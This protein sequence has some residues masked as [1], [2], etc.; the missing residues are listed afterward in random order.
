MYKYHFIQS[1][2]LKPL[3]R[4][5]PTAPVPQATR[6]PFGCFG[7]GSVARQQLMKQLSSLV[8]SRLLI[9]HL[10]GK[11]EDLVTG[12]TIY[13]SYHHNIG[14]LCWCC[15]YRCFSDQIIWHFACGCTQTS[16]LYFFN[17]HT[18]VAFVQHAHICTYII[19]YY[20]APEIP[21]FTAA[22]QWGFVWCSYLTIV[23]RGNWCV[24]PICSPMLNAL[25]M[26]KDTYEKILGFILGGIFAC[27]IL[28]LGPQF[29]LNHVNSSSKYSFGVQSFE[30]RFFT[31]FQLIYIYMISVYVYG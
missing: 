2:W 24:E 20:Y 27:Q 1:R 11:M 4:L 13:F 5:T 21:T 8:L 23:V 16:I 12:K 7:R 14:A 15:F 31:W 30:P 10:H 28:V 18:R 29:L 19:Y 26:P 6:R 9:L 3:Q 22:T 25:K 17:I